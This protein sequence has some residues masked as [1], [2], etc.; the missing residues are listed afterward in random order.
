M[1]LYLPMMR[2]P[3]YARNWRFSPVLK[4]A[5]FLMWLAGPTWLRSQAISGTVQDPSGAVIADARIE[6]TGGV[7]A[8]PIVLSSDGIGKFASPDLKPG[9]YSVRVTRDGF[10]PL[11]KI[12]DLQGSIQVQ[13]TL[14]IAKQQVRVSVA[15]KSLK[16]ANSDPVYRQLREL[17]LGQTFRSGGIPSRPQQTSR[18]VFTSAVINRILA[19]VGGASIK[20]MAGGVMRA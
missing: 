2:R 5:L 18:N 17:G 1:L 3:A 14:T 16:F 6:I 10:E 9:T 15:G 7:L 19:G 13:L 20:S 11:V 8:Q 12:V 4:M